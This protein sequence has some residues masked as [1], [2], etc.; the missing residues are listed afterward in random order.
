MSLVASSSFP[1]SCTIWDWAGRLGTSKKTG[2]PTVWMVGISS[3]QTQAKACPECDLQWAGPF[4]KLY[5][6]QASQWRCCTSCSWYQQEGEGSPLELETQPVARNG[7]LEALVDTAT[8]CSF[9]ESHAS[10]I[11]TGVAGWVWIRVWIRAFNCSI[12]AHVA[13]TSWW[14]WAYG[15][16]FSI[17]A[18]C[19]LYQT[20]PYTCH[21]ACVS[22]QPH[23][24]TQ[25]VGCYSQT[26]DLPPDLSS[27][28]ESKWL[29]LR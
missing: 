6:T 22:Q 3:K 12:S 8:S 11:S 26:G 17:S 14:E 4:T 15:F 27:L 18:C 5:A 1:S 25:Q 24:K 28:T 10:D 19:G 23:E 16:T 9:T 21:A 2:F 13:S 29:Q 7:E 20:G